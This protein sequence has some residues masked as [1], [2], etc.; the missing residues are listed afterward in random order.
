MAS[1]GTA[2]Q[3]LQRTRE[4]RQTYKKCLSIHLSVCVYVCVSVCSPITI[5]DDPRCRLSVSL[6][7]LCLSPTGH[8]TPTHYYE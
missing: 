4:T 8:A 6:Y 1:A 5:D 2:I 7:K 3:R